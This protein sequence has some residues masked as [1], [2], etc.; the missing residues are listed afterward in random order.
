MKSCRASPEDKLNPKSDFNRHSRRRVFQ[1]F[2][3]FFHFASEI[4]RHEIVRK[5]RTCPTH[6]KNVGAAA[7]SKHKK[8]VCHSRHSL[9]LS[10]FLFW[11]LVPLYF[12]ILLIG[13][14]FLCCLNSQLSCCTPL[15]GLFLHLVFTCLNIL[16]WHMSVWLCV[17]VCVSEHGWVDEC[18]N[19]C[20]YLCV[21]VYQCANVSK[22]VWMSRVF[23]LF[24]KL[25]GRYFHHSIWCSVILEWFIRQLFCLNLFCTNQSLSENFLFYSFFKQHFTCDPPCLSLSQSKSIDR[26][27]FSIITHFDVLPWLVAINKS[28][29]FSPN[30]SNWSV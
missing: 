22:C 7:D 8:I 14:L 9:L 13:K 29:L 24:K 5:M 11:S 23:A 26:E 3:S 30:H 16:C 1:C 18:S 20:V 21:H 2:F 17:Y 25:V 10:F 15:F 4:C 19:V 27:D 6:V 12:C 28:R